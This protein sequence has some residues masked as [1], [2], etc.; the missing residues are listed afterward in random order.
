MPDTQSGLTTGGDEEQR[1]GGGEISDSDFNDALAGQVEKTRSTEPDAPVREERATSDPAAP[2]TKREVFGAPD[3][4]DDRSV[5]HNITHGTTGPSEAAQ[6]AAIYAERDRVRAEIV[7]DPHFQEF[8]AREEG[9]ERTQAAE[10]TE[11][12]MARDTARFGAAQEQLE[13]GY[14]LDEVMAGL[15]QDRNDGALSQ[16]AYDAFVTWLAGSWEEGGGG[17]EPEEIG[18]AITQGHQYLYALSDQSI[19]EQAQVDALQRSVDMGENQD[20]AVAGFAAAKGIK[21]TD[22]LA[23]RLEAAQELAEYAGIDLLAIE[24]QD[25]FANALNSFDAH[26]QELDSSKR[27]QAWKE[28]TFTGMDTNVSSGLEQWSP[29]TGQHERM[30]TIRVAPPHVDPAKAD[31]RMKQRPEGISTAAFKRS[32]LAPDQKREDIETL[33]IKVRESDKVWVAQEA[34]RKARYR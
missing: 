31:A 7:A 3:T 17:Y 28:R 9:R 6:T 8:Q 5:E 19:A 13:Q 4:Q 1:V 26:A 18:A 20:L 10:A 12:Q 21:T 16:N 32:M 23:D 2:F 30:N 24:D 22:E 29:L 15:T 11:L 34:A 33:G 25:D 14:E 27:V